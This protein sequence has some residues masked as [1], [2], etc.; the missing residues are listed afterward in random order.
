MSR[1]AGIV[2]G[3]VLGAVPGVAL[4]ILTVPVSGEA[5][6]T[7]GVGGF[8]VGFVGLVIGAAL[9]ARRRERP[10]DDVR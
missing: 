5:E 1:L 3:A 7:L 4:V 6:L 8:F 10:V 9:G 2:A